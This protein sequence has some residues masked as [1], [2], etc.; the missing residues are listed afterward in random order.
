VACGAPPPD[1]PRQLSGGHG[2]RMNG[3]LSASLV[4]ALDAAPGWAGRLRLGHAPSLGAR[5]AA[6]NS[7]RGRARCEWWWDGF[8]ATVSGTEERNWY[9]HAA[10][11]E[12]M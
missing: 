12:E 11:F 6:N 3:Q 8:M 1:P 2:L 10:G 4:P 9:P 7:R 5:N